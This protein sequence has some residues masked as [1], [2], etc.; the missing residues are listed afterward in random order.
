LT[1]VGLQFRLRTDFYIMIGNQ[2]NI[3]LICI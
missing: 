3:Q 2:L 1:Q